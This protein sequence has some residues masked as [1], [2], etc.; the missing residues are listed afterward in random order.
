MIDD[1]KWRMISLKETSRPIELHI[2]AKELDGNLCNQFPGNDSVWYL[3]CRENKIKFINDVKT[4][5]N[6]STLVDFR[7]TGDFCLVYNLEGKSDKEIQLN[8]GGGG[9]GGSLCSSRMYHC[10]YRKEGKLYELKSELVF[11]QKYRRYS[12]TENWKKEGKLETSTLR[13]DS[14]PQ[15]WFLEKFS[16]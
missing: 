13:K 14:Y 11:S 12:P 15:F 7:G 1:D 10:D 4:L 16:S 2:N 5:S 6:G 8:L 9:R 3:F